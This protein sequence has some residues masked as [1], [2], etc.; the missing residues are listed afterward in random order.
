MH[1][2]SWQGSQVEL[3]S[4]AE[5]AGQV[6]A[7][8]SAPGTPF[9]ST[10]GEGRPFVPQDARPSA[11]NAEQVQD[12]GLPDLLPSPAGLSR[13][14]VCPQASAAQKR[15]GEHAGE[16]G[17]DP[18]FKIQAGGGAQ[19]PYLWSPS[20]VHAE[21][22]GK[23]YL[24][25]F[26]SHPGMEKRSFAPGSCEAEAGAQDRAAHT[27]ASRDQN[28]V[29]PLGAARRVGLLRFF[30]AGRENGG[31]DYFRQ[32][33]DEDE[34]APP[35]GWRMW[36]VV[37]LCCMVAFICYIDRAAIS[38]AMIPM[39]LE[40]GWNDHTKGAV[41]SV[42]FVG[43]TISNIAG[44]YLATRYTAKLVL[45]LGVLVWSAF[46]IATPL[47]AAN[48]DIYTLLACRMLM[49]A[50]EGVTFPAIQHLTSS[51]VPRR[52]RS[53][54]NSLVY[55]GATAGTVCAYVTAPFIIKGYGWPAL[56][57]VYGF[58]G[59]LW[60]VIWVPLVT[61][62]PPATKGFTPRREPVKSLGDV[63]WEQFACSRAVWAIL[64]CQSTQGVG[65]FLISIWVPS[66][67]FQQHGETLQTASLYSMAPWAAAI[68][69]TIAAGTFAD[70]LV[71]R[72]V[73]PLT[74]VRKLMQ[75]IG[76]FGPAA[77]LFYLAVIATAGTAIQALI[78]LT[79]CLVVE[80]FEA[81]GSAS[82]HL[83]ISPKY[84]G[85]IYGLTNGFSSIVEAL[86]IYGTGV[87][88]DSTHSWPLVFRIVASLHVL[89]GTTYLILASTK[90]QFE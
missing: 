2:D 35:G 45:G 83:D 80:S 63:P 47:A 33:A 42:F 73:L 14:S 30:G 4:R 82:N 6:S 13:I 76:S 22:K 84:A 88:L 40:Y 57:F 12:Q 43:Y 67:F 16:H 77:C 9:V 37:A 71:N 53:R 75:A 62:D 79:V 51:W 66:F 20:V 58:V 25:D 31:D 69:A 52:Q 74:W 55:A 90:R 29:T 8:P 54:A 18:S 78:V 15:G 87:I 72:R 17:A 46:T 56:F 41:N 21:G 59:L 89:G 10:G 7:A 19:L 86:S 24:D 50:G 65:Q 28:A 36:V 61:E 60:C 3:L 34:N 44:G 85:I 70:M 5:A 81:A 26:G 68:V 38:V 11:L 27:D 64:I 32:Y 39:G 1:A 49:G 48:G 23:S